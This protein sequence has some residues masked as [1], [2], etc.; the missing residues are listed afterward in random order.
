MLSR[1]NFILRSFEELN[2]DCDSDFN[3]NFL[4]KH[5]T[6]ELDSIICNVELRANDLF[7]SHRVFSHESILPEDVQTKVPISTNNSAFYRAFDD[8]TVQP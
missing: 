7:N 3:S 2:R 4:I 1:D 5:I 8:G 6:S